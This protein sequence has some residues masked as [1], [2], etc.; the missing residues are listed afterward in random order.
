MSMHIR[1]L[2]QGTLIGEGKQVSF[3]DPGLWIMGDLR[4]STRTLN[5]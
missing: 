5:G 2:I 3:R 1:Y 4:I